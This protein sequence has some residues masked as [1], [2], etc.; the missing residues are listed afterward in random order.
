MTDF[1]YQLYSSRNF[2]PLDTTLGMLKRNGYARVEGYGALYTEPR[3]IRAAL[4]ANGLTMPSGHF[5]ID[6]LENEPQKVL[7]IAGML[8]MKAIYC[9]H[10]AIEQRPADAAG[11]SAFGERLEAAHAVYSKAGY[12]FGWHNHDFEFKALPDG[13][14]PQKLIFDAAPSISWEADIA[15]IIRGGADPF[16]WIENH[17][18]RIS[19]V[20][21]KDIAP[22]G[23]NADEDGW[24]D[25]GH[26]TVDWKALL[27]A[28]RATPVR[29]FIME[30]DNPSDHERFARRSIATV[31]A[32]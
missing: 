16:Q 32:F 10:L 28:L 4:D 25:V 23:E 21:I 22:S 29:Y 9:P 6:L 14:I 8:G 15:W 13:A 30:H 31:K 5:S 24:A 2:P 27:T 1:S 17:G 20:H 3:A 11:W 26:G 19:A 18:K 7:D 12:V